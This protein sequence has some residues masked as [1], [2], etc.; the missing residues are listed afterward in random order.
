VTK[1]ARIEN[2]KLLRSMWYPWNDVEIET[3]LFPPQ[4]ETPLWHVRIHRIKTGRKLISAEGGFAIYGQR[5]DGRALEPSEGEEFGTYEKGG[6]GRAASKAGVSGIV[7]LGEVGSRKGCAL[8]TD[9]NSNLI[10]ARAVLPTLLGEHEAGQ[11]DI[12]LGAGVFGLPNVGESEGATPGW[13]RHWVKRPE[14]GMSVF[15]YIK[16][17]TDI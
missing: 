2:G 9:A 17:Q 5:K 3:W 10:V 6:E 14:V 1:E 13:S 4:P 7:E 8:R 16:T 15:D 11:G 12:W